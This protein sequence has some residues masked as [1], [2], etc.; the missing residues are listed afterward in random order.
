MKR[1]PVLATSLAAL[2]LASCAP[3][4]D[5]EDG[6][7]RSPGMGYE[8]AAAGELKL[9]KALSQTGE[10]IS[11]SNPDIVEIDA[12]ALAEKLAEGNVRLIDVRTDEEVAE[13]IIPGAEHVALDRFDPALLDLSDGREVVLYCRSGRRSAIAAEALAAHIGEP[14]EHLDGGILGWQEAGEPIVQP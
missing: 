5:G 14:V 12:K 13:G 4:G 1:A 7:S 11:E 6:G 8:L 9:R 2:A 3:S 10:D